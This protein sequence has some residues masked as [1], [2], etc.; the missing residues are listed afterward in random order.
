MVNDHSE[1]KPAAATWATLSEQKELMP[2][3]QYDWY[4]WVF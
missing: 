2:F 1:S 3:K 4:Y